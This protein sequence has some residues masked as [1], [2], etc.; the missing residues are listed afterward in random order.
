MTQL[1][2]F[3]APPAAKKSQRPSIDERFRLFHAENPHVLNEMYRIAR[4]KITAGATRI[5]VKALWEELRESLRV[6]KQGDFK[7]DN[8]FT[9]PY[10]RALIDA[11]PELGEFIEIRTRHSKRKK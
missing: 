4:A 11:A 2:M 7:L 9:A 5:G 8:S 6:Q 10:A 1:S 3:D